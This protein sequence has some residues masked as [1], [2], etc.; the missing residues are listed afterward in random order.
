MGGVQTKFLSKGEFIMTN[1]KKKKGNKMKLLSAVG[2]LT[3]S[4]AMLVSSTFAWFSLNKNVTA[5]SMSVTAKSNAKY[6]LVG[7]DATKAASTA[8]TD[9][10]GK[11]LTTEH[12]ALKATTDNDDNIVYPV[13]YYKT[14]GTLGTTA[15]TANSWF[16]AYNEHSNNATDA[17]IN[18]MKV[19]EGDKDYMIHYQL[20]LTLSNGSENYTGKLKTTFTLENGDAATSAVV[21]VNDSTTDKQKLNSTTATF[22]TSSD[23]TITA[24]TAVPVDVYVFIDGN[25]TNVYTNYIADGTT[26]ITGNISLGFEIENPN[27]G[28]FT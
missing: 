23:V 4:A 26:Q 24:G 19:T 27:T 2:M 11:A 15:T 13:D 3:V 14:A 5:T 8:K 18:A 6:L 17:I 12:A 1:T 25:S 10:A 28:N 16:T 20:W 21:V 7:D 9:K 22:T